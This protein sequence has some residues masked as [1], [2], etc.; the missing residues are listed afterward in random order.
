MCSC[1]V[2]EAI[3]HLRR[4]A[5][6]P[7]VNSEGMIGWIGGIPNPN[8]SLLY[9]LDSLTLKYDEEVKISMSCEYGQ[10]F[11]RQEFRQ[12]QSASISTIARASRQFHT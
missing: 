4:E 10:P 5:L 6:K 7:E 8:S 9:Y 11:V 1:L 2:V 3:R 12:L